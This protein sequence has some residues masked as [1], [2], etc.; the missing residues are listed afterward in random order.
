MKR[1]KIEKPYIEYLIGAVKRG[2]ITHEEALFWVNARYW[3][4]TI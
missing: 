4:K 2:Q 3:R 1:I